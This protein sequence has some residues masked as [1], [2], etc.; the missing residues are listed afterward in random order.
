MNDNEIEH[1]TNK[2]QTKQNNNNES[3]NKHVNNV[4]YYNS[5]NK[6]I[7]EIKLTKVQCLV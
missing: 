5:T 3:H 2:N 4:E 7:S 6:P 1:L